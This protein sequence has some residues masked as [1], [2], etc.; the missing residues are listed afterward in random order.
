MCTQTRD[1]LWTS[2]WSR[3]YDTPE[4]STTIPLHVRKWMALPSRITDRELDLSSPREDTLRTRA[5]MH[6]CSL[7]LLSIPIIKFI[8]GSHATHNQPM[9]MTLGSPF[10]TQVHLTLGL[11]QPMF[12]NTRLDATR[13]MSLFMSM[14]HILYLAFLLLPFHLQHGHHIVIQ[15]SSM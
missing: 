12:F 9:F 11:L 3:S 14:T 8:L 5:I 7:T 15:S 10:F 6:K 4:Y 2:M 1:C 13:S